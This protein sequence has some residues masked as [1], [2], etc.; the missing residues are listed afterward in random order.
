[1]RLTPVPLYERENTPYRNNCGRYNRVWV[2]PLYVTFDA[3]IIL[4]FLRTYR[5][6]YPDSSGMGRMT[7][8]VHRGYVKH[9]IKARIQSCHIH[10][11]D[12]K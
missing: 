6:D 5:F 7:P 3:L 9:T 11:T 2:A 12:M 10:F 4:E 8:A 1:M